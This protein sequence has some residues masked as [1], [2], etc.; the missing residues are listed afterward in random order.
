MNMRA[1]IILLLVAGL[2]H[3][4]WGDEPIPATQP[5]AT[6][7]AVDQTSPRGAVKVLETAMLNGDADGIV[8]DVDAQ[9]PDQSMVI[10]AFADSVSARSQLQQAV[11]AKFPQKGSDMKMAQQ[12]QMVMLMRMIDSMNVHE[13]G[14]TAALEISGDPNSPHFSVTKVGETWKIPFTS[15]FSGITNAK[16]QAK[17]IGVQTRTFKDLATDI[18]AG[19]FATLEQLNGA[20]QQRMQA[21]MQEAQASMAPPAA[22]GPPA[23]QP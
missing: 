10:R 15:V 8:G 6:T 16:M 7:A 11:A 21:A 3:M 19:K 13:N 2:A 18:S 23:T 1:S 4:A 12:Q 5:A 20:A 17:M 14:N 9:S 22:S